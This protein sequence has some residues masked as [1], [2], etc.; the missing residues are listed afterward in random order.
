MD[1]TTLQTWTS[2]LD[3]D[4]RAARDLYEA[5]GLTA[6]D[7]PP[8]DIDIDAAWTR[9]S[10]AVDT[11]KGAKVVSLADAPT[12]RRSRY[13]R[14]ATAAAVAA[15]VLALVNVVAGLGDDRAE[16][17]NAT[18]EAMPVVLPDDSEAML[19]PGSEL[20]YAERDG[21]REV[22]V[23]GEVGFA[24]T[25]DPE[26]AFAVEAA[27]LELVVVGTKFMVNRDGRAGV[28]VSEGHVRVRGRREADWTDVYGGGY[29]AV[30]D[31]LVA[32]ARPGAAASDD[33]RFRERP[34]SE[35]LERLGA[36]H[37]VALTAAAPLRDCR[38]TANLSEAS[39]AEA[40]ETIA[41][42]LGARVEPLSEGAIHLAGGGCR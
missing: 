14:W 17:A 30:V 11:P 3:G 33:L 25:H 5:V 37:A 16:F 34:L 10:A 32:Q 26:M 12:S 13:V 35:V 22:T 38:L 19:M 24:V 15:L 40:V 1:E 31:G 42:T 28:A 29:V 6:G 2:A 27:E 20:R 18:A 21:R 4:A 39:L 7:V 8:A 41:L 9:V 23:A 36:H